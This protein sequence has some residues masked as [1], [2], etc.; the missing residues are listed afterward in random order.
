[1]DI[2]IRIWGEK[3]DGE[4]EGIENKRVDNVKFLFNKYSWVVV[5]VEEIR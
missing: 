4:N 1:M 5:E 2:F 3:L